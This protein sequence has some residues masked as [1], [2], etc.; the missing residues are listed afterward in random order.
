M[1]P[2]ELKALADDLE[3]QI[4]ELQAGLDQAE[5]RVAE[6]RVA[7][8]EGALYFYSR[9]EAYRNKGKSARPITLDAGKIARQALTS[10]GSAAP[11]ACA[12]VRP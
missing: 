8:L 2:F 10:D 3:N 11:Q 12:P 5:G 6:G 1:D 4:A 7:E 9:P